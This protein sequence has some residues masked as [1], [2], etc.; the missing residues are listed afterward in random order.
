MP[1][2]RSAKCLKHL[3]LDKIA[4]TVWQLAAESGNRRNCSNKNYELLKQFLTPFNVYGPNITNSI[5]FA[6]VKHYDLR[7]PAI[8]F[9][10]SSMTVLNL[11]FIQNQEDTILIERSIKT[12]ILVNCPRIEVL[13]LNFCTKISCE[14]VRLLIT[15]S[16]DTLRRL[17]L[18]NVT[19][20]GNIFEAIGKCDK[21]SYLDISRDFEHSQKFSFYKLAKMFLIYG[22]RTGLAR[23]L[24]VLHMNN[25]DCASKK[26]FRFFA[27]IFY[28]WC[29]QLSR[30]THHLLFKALAHLCKLNKGP[31]P[32]YLKGGND[33][34][35]SNRLCVSWF[36]EQHDAL[37]QC[38]PK[39]ENLNIISG[40]E[41]NAT[42]VYIIQNQRL[43]LT[44]LEL[45][46]IHPFGFLKYV[47]L[48]C[49]YLEDVTVDKVFV[50]TQN[51]LVQVVKEEFEKLSLTALE[52]GLKPWSKLKSLC[53][54]AANSYLE[55]EDITSLLKTICKNS[56]GS[57]KILSLEFGIHSCA[58]D[59]LNELFQDGTLRDLKDLLCLEKDVTPNMIWD[60]LTFDNSLKFIYV[61]CSQINPVLLEIEQF[62]RYIDEKNLDLKIIRC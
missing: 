46:W 18:Q 40:N 50:E 29:P 22:K 44:T 32:L 23:N 12:F 31:K 19:L 58:Y 20:S 39:M 9:F 62:N 45:S 30:F 17:E 41:K 24:E 42:I 26:P 43:Q 60:W 57:L 4:Q 51:N 35:D 27:H 21:L 48:L 25:V 13:C 7:W 8:S 61:K 52:T 11:S 6:L 14:V 3:V 47:G 1:R 36:E 59:V 15:A 5:N 28:Y 2:H 10:G 33:D 55:D 54:R 53:M 56:S 38:V 37:L 34:T 16:K 49:P